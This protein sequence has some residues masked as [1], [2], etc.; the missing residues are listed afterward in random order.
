MTEE[1]NRALGTDTLLLVDSG[2]QYLDGTTDITRTVALGDPERRPARPSPVCCRHGCHFAGA[3][4]QRIVRPRPRPA[5]AGALWMAGQD[6]DHGTGHG[7]GV[8]LSVHEGP[9][10]ISAFRKCRLSPA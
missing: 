1:T 4:S 5:G 3:F 7:V 6:Y 8:F 10:R 9:Q 2:G